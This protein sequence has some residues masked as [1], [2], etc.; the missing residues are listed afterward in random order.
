[1]I[2]I[3]DFPA[4]KYECSMSPKWVIVK[5]KYCIMVLDQRNKK[6]APNQPSDKFC[7]RR[8]EHIS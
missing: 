5:Q 2:M 4:H 6:A 1:M 8:L 7:H 3:S